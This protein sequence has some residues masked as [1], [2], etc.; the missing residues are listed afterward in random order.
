MEEEKRRHTYGRQDEGML[1]AA[2]RIQ[3]LPLEA[4]ELVA[5]GLDEQGESNSH[6]HDRRGLSRDLNEMRL[7][8]VLL[9]AIT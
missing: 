8:D 4:H 7:Q 1:R 3:H 5:L 2:V 9:L 6:E